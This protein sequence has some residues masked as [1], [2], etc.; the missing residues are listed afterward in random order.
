MGGLSWQ[1]IIFLVDS[2]VLAHNFEDTYAH[3]SIWPVK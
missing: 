2:I 1:L 3:K